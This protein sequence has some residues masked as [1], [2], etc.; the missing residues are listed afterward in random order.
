M[1]LNS[2]EMSVNDPVWS[3]GVAEGSRRHRSWIDRYQGRAGREHRRAARFTRVD[4][5][6]RARARARVCVCVYV[7]EEAVRHKRVYVYRC[8]YM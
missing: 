5:C 2:R 7:C 8:S 6:M 3:V 1:V 4:V